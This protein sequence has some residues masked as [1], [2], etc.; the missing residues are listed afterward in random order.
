M[1]TA[2]TL[3]LLI[4][5]FLLAGCTSYNALVNFKEGPKIPV[6]PQAIKNFRPITIQPN[7]IL[8][9]TVSS[10]DAVAVQPFKMS[11]NVEGGG[12]QSAGENFL[13]SSEGTIDFPTIGTINIEGLTIEEAK[14]KIIEQLKPY[15][16]DEPIVQLRLT[17]FKVMVNGEVGQ[18]GSYSVQNDRM[19][20]IEALTLAGDFTSYSR[21]DSI[22]IIREKAGERSFGYVDF[23]SYEVFNSPY[24]YLQQNDVIYVQPAKSKVNDI[25]DPATRFLPWVSAAVSITALI[26]TVTR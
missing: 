14:A 4:S 26:I 8:N 20:I 2:N 23:N 5:L 9:I 6:D 3:L 1:R 11:G 7:D 19:T 17:N 15:F 22:M 18:P 10:S 16:Q 12:T 24:F 13:V 21:R 25:R